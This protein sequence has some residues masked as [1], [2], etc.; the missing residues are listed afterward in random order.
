MNGLCTI[1]DCNMSEFGNTTTAEDMVVAIVKEFSAV[2]AKEGVNL[3]VPDTIAYIKATWNPDTIGH[4]Y[5]SM[6]QDLITNHR[7]TEIDYIN[8]VIARRGKKYG[9][10]TPYC[11]FLTQLVHAKEQLLHAK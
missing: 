1:L 3:N 9:I 11:T 5:P 10:P 7:L 8:G 4:H 6:H 2:A